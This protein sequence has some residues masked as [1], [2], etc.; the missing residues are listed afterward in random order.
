MTKYVSVYRCRLCGVQYIEGGTDL[1]ILAVR[2]A[3]EATLSGSGVEVE[4][5]REN[6]PTLFSVHYCKDGGIGVSEFLGF[7]KNALGKE[8]QK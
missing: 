4:H 6:A 2:S 8:T 1:A 5:R 3:S 7:K